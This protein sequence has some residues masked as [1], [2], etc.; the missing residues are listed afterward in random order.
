MIHELVSSIE[1]EF[2]VFY[3]NDDTMGGDL[4][5]LMADLRKSEEHGRAIGLTF[6]V[7][8]SELISHD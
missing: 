2:K 5:D 4:E 3:L 1:S 6:N 7:H 8:K